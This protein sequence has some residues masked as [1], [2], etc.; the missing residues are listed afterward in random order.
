M[1]GLGRNTKLDTNAMQQ[2][3][4]K[5]TKQQAMKE[6]M[7]KNMEAKQIAKLTAE[8]SAAASQSQKPAITDEE[9]FAIF[10]NGENVERTPRGAKPSVDNVGKKKKK[11]A[12]K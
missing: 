12:G 5:M 8:A 4:D 9:L 1:A 3:M 10:S 7:R 2:R 6:R 11:K